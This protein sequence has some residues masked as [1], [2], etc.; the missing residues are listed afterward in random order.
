MRVALPYFGAKRV[1]SGWMV[2]V[3]RLSITLAIVCGTAACAYLIYN[4]YKPS[5][6]S[7]SMAAQKASAEQIDERYSKAIDKNLSSKNYIS[8]QVSKLEIAN[9]Y[10]SAKDFSKAKESLDDVKNN[11]PSSKLQPYYFVL[12]L[13]I[14]ENNHD[15][16][17]Q[18]AI[19]LNL[20]NI[21][22]KQGNK[23]QA[24]Y[25]QKKISSLGGSQ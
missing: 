8:Y 12:R 18:K 10:I 7:S 15:V 22:T 11:V 16:D 20:I 23:A 9:S 6:K 2:E 19:M 21:L 24:D 14:A 3:L 13:A 17:A 25:Y 1:A 5:D 4:H